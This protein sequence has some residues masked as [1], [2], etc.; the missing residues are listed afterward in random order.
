M[1]FILLFL[2]TKQQR[3]GD[4]NRYIV[5][6]LI[7]ENILS[8]G[9]HCSYIVSMVPLQHNWNIL[10]LHAHITMPKNNNNYVI[11]MLL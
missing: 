9:I 1:D 11:I 8:A 7:Q 3:E 2:T 10:H 4:R 5:V 6:S